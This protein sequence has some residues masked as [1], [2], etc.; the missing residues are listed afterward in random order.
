MTDRAALLARK[1]RLLGV[2]A[3]PESDVQAVEAL[4]E[5]DW[6]RDRLAALPPFPRPAPPPVPA[7]GPRRGAARVP[8]RSA[9][10]DS[11]ALAA[12]ERFDWQG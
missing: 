10:I 8:R 2:Y 1:A 3:S 6:I 7:R 9:W 5:L 4:A 11:A 12:G